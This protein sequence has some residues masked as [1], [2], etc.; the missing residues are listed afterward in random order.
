DDANRF[1]HV[2]DIN[3]AAL[4]HGA[5]LDHELGGFRNGHEVTGD[6]RVGDGDRPAVADLLPELWYDGTGRA[7]HIAEPHHGE[8]AIMAIGLPITGGQALDDL[9]RNPLGRAHDVGWPYRLVGRNED[10]AL[11]AMSCSGL[12]YVAGADDVV[13]K[14]GAGVLFVKR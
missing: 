1:A 12:G 3:L 10:E 6:V 7:E 2:E 14:A 4:G 11:H 5:G 13:A 9:L 8:D